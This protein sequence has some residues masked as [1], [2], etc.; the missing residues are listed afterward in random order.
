MSLDTDMI[1]W[2]LSLCYHFVHDWA[3]LSLDVC[4][5]ESVV[6]DSVS[7]NF[8]EIHVLIVSEI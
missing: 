1:V 6:L 2:V 8:Y 7:H 4:H 5:V 3:E